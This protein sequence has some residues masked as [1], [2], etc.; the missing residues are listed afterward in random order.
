[1]FNVTFPMRGFYSMAA[2]WL[3]LTASSWSAALVLFSPTSLA[4]TIA[5][6]EDLARPINAVILAM[7]LL[8]WADVIWHDVGGRLI[9]PSLDGRIRHHLCVLF[10]SVLAGMFA[11][12]AFVAGDPDSV[13]SWLLGSYYLLTASG[14][15]LVVVSIAHEDRT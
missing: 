14:I 15:A 7:T 9:W 2:R 8:G 1:M 6:G 3:A 5:A 13:Q 4:A 10:Y 12:R 11:I